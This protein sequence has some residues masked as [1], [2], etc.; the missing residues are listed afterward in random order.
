LISRA[1]LITHI[2][3]RRDVVKS[4]F[5]SVSKKKWG[6][7]KFLPLQC[8]GLGV[9]WFLRCAQSELVPSKPMDMMWDYNWMVVRVIMIFSEQTFATLN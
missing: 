3:E 8:S 4:C 2:L 5:F 7:T 6:R 1:T 9:G